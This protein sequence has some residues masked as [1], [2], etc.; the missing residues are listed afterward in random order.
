MIKRRSLS[1][2]CMLDRISVDI[3]DWCMVDFLRRCWMNVLGRLY[4]SVVT[5]G[6]YQAITTLSK[7]FENGKRRHVWPEDKIIVTANLNINYRA[8]TKVN[9]FVVIKSILTEV[10]PAS[11]WILTVGN[12][13]QSKDKRTDRNSGRDPRFALWR[14]RL[15]CKT[16]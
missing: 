2:W 10:F 7:E 6:W 16:K 1:L 9:Q 15:I 11:G 13:T 5:P 3:E 4:L 14:R 8:P 12:G